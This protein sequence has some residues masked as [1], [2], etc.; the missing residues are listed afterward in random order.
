MSKAL[1]TSNMGFQEQSVGNV[2]LGGDDRLADRTLYCGNSGLA[3]L[4]L[5]D[6]QASDASLQRDTC[7]QVANNPLKYAEYRH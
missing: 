3:L 4:P 2:R 7:Q 5:L 6:H 1:V